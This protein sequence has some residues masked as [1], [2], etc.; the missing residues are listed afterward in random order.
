MANTTFTD[1]VTPIVSS[2]LNDANNVLYTLLGNGVNVPTTRPQ[3]LANLG[4]AGILSGTTA[5]RPVGVITGTQYFD[6]TL[7]QPVWYLAGGT[8]WVNAAGAHV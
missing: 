6:T 3:L 4:V 1:Q 7:G 2:W 5:L 8:N